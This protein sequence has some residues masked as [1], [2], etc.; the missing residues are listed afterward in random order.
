GSAW[1][2]SWEPGVVDVDVDDEVGDVTAVAVRVRPGVVAVVVVLDEAAVDPAGH[3]DARRSGRT[4][5]P[6]GVATRAESVVGCRRVLT[7]A[8][9]A[10]TA[11]Y[12]H[13][14]TVLPVDINLTA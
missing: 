5:H 2:Y 14:C 11:L 8:R 3:A 6:C 10:R 13:S 7:S 4:R 1:A 12:S 9:L